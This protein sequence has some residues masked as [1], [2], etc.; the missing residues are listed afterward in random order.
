VKD[1]EGEGED[2]AE[3]VG[4]AGALLVRSGP[5]IEAALCILNNLFLPCPSP[6]SSVNCRSF[7]SSADSGNEDEEAE[8][9]EEE[10][11]EAK[12]E[13]CEGE[14]EGKTG[15]VGCFLSA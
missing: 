1:E 6:Y 3:P 2:E 13:A 10:E 4:T 7:A 8:A 14:S 15:L 9:A 12:E 5:N 11:E